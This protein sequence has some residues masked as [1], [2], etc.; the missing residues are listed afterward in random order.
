MLLFS[1][2]CLLCC[3]FSCE[4]FFFLFDAFAYFETNYSN[5]GKILVYR[6]QVLR[7]CLLAVLCSNV[8]LIQKT[9]IL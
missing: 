4:I 5:E 9:D 1:G 6:S 2:S 3:Y 8:S 7:H